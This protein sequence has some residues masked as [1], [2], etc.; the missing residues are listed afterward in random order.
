LLLRIPGKLA[1][2]FRFRG[3]LGRVC[4]CG[5]RAHSRC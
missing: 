2:D 1:V 4:C 5:P 3:K